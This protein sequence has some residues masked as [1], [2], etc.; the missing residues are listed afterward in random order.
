L[1]AL[2]AQGLTQKDLAERL[3][4]TPQQISKI[5]KGEENLTLETITNLELALGIHIILD[6]STPNKSAA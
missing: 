4:V 6:N 3:N 2:K 5:V 1:D